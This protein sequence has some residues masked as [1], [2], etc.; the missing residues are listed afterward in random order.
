MFKTFP[1]RAF[2]TFSFIAYVGCRIVRVEIGQAFSWLSGLD[3]P[4][5]PCLVP[6][7]VH[8][9][10]DDLEFSL[11]VLLKSLSPFLNT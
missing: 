3:N 5:Y 10:G 9:S 4:L 1:M 11:N 7:L 8:K 6:F 2:R